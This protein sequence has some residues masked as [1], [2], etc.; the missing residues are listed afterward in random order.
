[1][2]DKALLIGINRYK[3]SPLNG[4]VN[5]I[6]DMANLLVG[7]YR[8]KPDNIRLL[9]DERATTAGIKDRLNWLVDVGGKDRC[10]FHYSGH[11]AQYPSRN[12]K[13]ELDGKLEICCPVEFDWTEQHMITDKYFVGIF[14]KIPGGVKFNWVSDSC[15]SG[16]LTRDIGEPNGITIQIP[17]AY[18]VPVDIAWR[19]KGQGSKKMTNRKIYN[20]VLD[21]GFISGCRSDQTSAD[22]TIN[23]RWNGALTHFLIDSLKRLPVNT[24]LS[25]IVADTTNNLIRNRYSQRPQ[26]E[27]LRSKMPLFG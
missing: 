5:D 13:Q 8:F 25:K 20:G 6:N 27:G 4:C 15:H 22:T 3:D 17:R 11:G 9:A 14:S 23:K 24:A 18:P 12:Y 16:D 10:F 7:K 19:H 1:M 26:V 21:V 2:G